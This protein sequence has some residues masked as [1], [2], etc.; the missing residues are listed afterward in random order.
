MINGEERSDMHFLYFYNFLDE[1]IDYPA[2]SFWALNPRVLE[3]EYAGKKVQSEDIVEDNL[4]LE[5][6][7]SKGHV[8]YILDDRSTVAEIAIR[9]LKSP[10]ISQ[11][12]FFNLR[13]FNKGE[14]MSPELASGIEENEITGIK[15]LQDCIFSVIRE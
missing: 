9:D 11:L 4:K 1:L 14:Y 3:D 13:L 8:T 10:L 2:S 6:W 5:S 12:D 15:Y 7:I